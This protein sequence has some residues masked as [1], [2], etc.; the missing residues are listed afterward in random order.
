MFDRVLNTPLKKVLQWFCLRE[1]P[2][3]NKYQREFSITHSSEI[4]AWIN[5][6]PVNRLKQD[7]KIALTVN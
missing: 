6:V 3:V 2:D 5:F 4:F 1:L 7:F